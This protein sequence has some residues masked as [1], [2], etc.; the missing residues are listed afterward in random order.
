MLEH[1]SLRNILILEDTIN[2]MCLEPIDVGLIQGLMI[3][4]M[5][6]VI[7]LLGYKNIVTKKTNSEPYPISQQES[8]S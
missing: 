6:F 1:L 4:G 2:I 3:G 7:G 8:F 5:T